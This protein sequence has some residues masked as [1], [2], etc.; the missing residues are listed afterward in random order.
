MITFYNFAGRIKGVPWNPNVWKIRYALNYKGI[1]YKTVWLE[2]PDIELPT[3]HHPSHYDNSTGTAIAE[4][5]DKTYPSTPRLIPQGTHA[6]QG[7]FRDAFYLNAEYYEQTRCA[8]MGVPTLEVLRV[9]AEARDAEWDKVKDAFGYVHGL[10]KEN[11]DW[12]M[13]DTISFA[14]FIVASMVGVEWKNFMSWHGG[15]WERLMAAL[16]KYS[17]V[18]SL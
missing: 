13:G 11:D 6:L 5:L 3:V 10:M 14:D 16:D 18:P 8:D 12:I 1:A 9:P 15:R 4:Y 7:A 17:A 2:Y